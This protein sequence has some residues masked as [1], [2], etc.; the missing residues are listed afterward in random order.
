MVEIVN[1]VAS[2]DFNRE[3]D[4]Y[5]L[6]QDISDYT[7]EARFD[8]ESTPGL[9]IRLKKG[10]AMVIVYSTGKF[11]IMGAKSTSEIDQILDDFNRIFTELNIEV[12][13]EGSFAE[14]RNIIC[15]ED[16][17]IELDLQSLVLDLGEANTEYEPEQ[18]PFIYYRPEK[19]DCL[20]TIPSSGEI[21][22]TGIID[23]SEASA[24]IDHLR[25]RL[26]TITPN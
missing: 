11:T 26:K 21:V 20:I 15:K 14:I 3:F 22:V 6:H 2:G 17:E 16:L 7:E 5:R 19:L 12:N 1:V 18:S 10:G 24:A 8:P 23:I 4:L 9:Q 25:D 13:H